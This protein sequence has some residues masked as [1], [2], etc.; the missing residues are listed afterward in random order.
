MDRYT[1]LRDE[2]N[3]APKILHFRR[4]TQAID[5]TGVSEGLNGD[6]KEVPLPNSKVISR[7][8]GMFKLGIELCRL[9]PTVIYAF[10]LDMLFIAV[11]VKPF[12]NA[13]IVYE[14][15]DINQDGFFWR[16][17]ENLLLIFADNVLLTSPFF[18][19]ALKLWRFSRKKRYFISNAPRT[20][21]IKRSLYIQGTLKSEKLTVGVFGMIREKQQ[22]KDIK[23][24]LDQTPCNLWVAGTSIYPGEL[25]ILALE[26]P[27]RL[28]VTGA[29]TADYLYD[30]L[31]PNVDCVWAV[32]PNSLNYRM[33]LARRFMEALAL[34]KFVIVG[35]H[36]D[37]M[38]DFAGDSPLLIVTSLNNYQNLA[39]RIDKKTLSDHQTDPDMRYVFETYAS[40]LKQISAWSNP[41]PTES[42]GND[43]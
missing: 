11:L 1:Y 27:D 25:N 40:P 38:I 20:T 43:K 41:T 35:S 8:L 5:L 3:C 37:A 6:A 29:F 39:S 14:V 9:H 17:L 34:R 16:L 31:Y 15:Q 23:F 24:L 36:A 22:I 7:L 21:E 10:Y 12:C 26:Y 13:K 4:T 2:A 19:K 42:L 18:E 30:V 32:Y 28:R 33:H